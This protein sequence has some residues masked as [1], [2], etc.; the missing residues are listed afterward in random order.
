MR[1]VQPHKIQADYRYEKMARD[2]ALKVF[3]VRF[4]LKLLAEELVP[5]K[6]VKRQLD[7]ELRKLVRTL[8]SVKP[9]GKHN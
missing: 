5:A 9:E 2:I 8:G 7:K 6:D 3:Q 4:Y 1:R